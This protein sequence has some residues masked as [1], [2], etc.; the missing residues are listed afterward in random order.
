MENDEITPASSIFLMRP[1]H[2]EG[3][4]PTA[5]PISCRLARALAC[6]NLQYFPVCFIHKDKL[7]FLL[8]ISD[9]ISFQATSI[10]Q[11]GKTFQAPQP[12][13]QARRPH[14]PVQAFRQAPLRV[15]SRRGVLLPSRG[16][17]VQ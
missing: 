12:T 15:T 4:N 8:N 14:L 2:G 9:K 6:K 13:I 10:A 11:T 16:L 5:W 7:S 17:A 1:Q 3:L